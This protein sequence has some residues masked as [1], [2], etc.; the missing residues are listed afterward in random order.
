M[1]KP[2]LSIPSNAVGNYFK[3]GAYVQS[4]PSRGDKP[5]AFGE[6]VVYNATVKH[7]PPLV[8]GL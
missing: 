7:T 3:V 2:A 6:V 1:D 8:R 4:N 5:D